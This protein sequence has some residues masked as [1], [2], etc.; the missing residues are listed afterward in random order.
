MSKKK[1][2]LMLTK[3]QVNKI[4]E[5]AVDDAIEQALMILM[6]TLKEKRGYKVRAMKQL[7]TQV[8]ELCDSIKKGY[9]ST[10]DIRDWYLEQGIDIKKIFS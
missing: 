1:K 7:A 6:Y 2:P 3:G 10:N 8:N 4:K 5:K 9:L